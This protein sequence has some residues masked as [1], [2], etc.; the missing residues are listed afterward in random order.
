MSRNVIFFI[1]VGFGNIIDLCR[2]LLINLF[3]ESLQ[4]LKLTTTLVIRTLLGN[5]LSYP[6]IDVYVLYSNSILSVTQQTFMIQCHY[7]SLGLLGPINL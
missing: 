6:N 2:D 3:V 1:D 5:E 4:A 7:W